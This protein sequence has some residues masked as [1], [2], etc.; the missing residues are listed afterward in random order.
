MRCVTVCGGSSVNDKNGGGTLPG[1]GKVSLRT[2]H[3]IE[4]RTARGAQTVRIDRRIQAIVAA[5]TLAVAMWVGVGTQAILA[6]ASARAQAEAAVAA[7][8]AEV[9]AMQRELAAIRADVAARAAKLEARQHA[10]A[11]MLSGKAD[12]TALAALVEAPAPRASHGGVA[13]EIAVTLAALDASQ[14]ALAGKA[15]TAAEARYRDTVTLLRRLGLSPDRF[16]QQSHIGTGGP[17][18]PAGAIEPR[19]RELFMSWKRLDLLEKA[20]SAIPSFKPVKSYTYTS[21]YGVRF[22]PFTGATAMHAGVDMSGP[23]GEPVY[24]AADG[25]VT[26]AGWNGAYGN[27]VELDHGKGIDTRYGHLSSV[28]VKPGAAVRKGDLIG[29]MGSTGRST[30]SHLHY[31]VR[32]DDRAVNPMPFLEAGEELAGIQAAPGAALGGPPAAP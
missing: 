25:T 22:D 16:V 8:E 17:L 21:G 9:A 23:V 13:G 29:R 5:A 28:A 15:T 26:R 1:W 30:G 18:E 12:A 4:L 20:M 14:G 2:L 32:I 27:L 7:K 10:M 3:E 31:E 19:F 11:A 6:K 24:A